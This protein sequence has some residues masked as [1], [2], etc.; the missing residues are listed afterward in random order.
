MKFPVK[1][2]I[3]KFIYPICFI[4]FVTSNKIIIIFDYEHRIRFS[5]FIDVYIVPLRMNTS[6][7]Y[8]FR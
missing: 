1:K 4:G 8:S 7:A 2:H 5:I 6:N 3:L